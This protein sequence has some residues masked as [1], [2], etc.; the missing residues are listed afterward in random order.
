MSFGGGFFG[1]GTSSKKTYTTQQ[2]VNEAREQNLQIGGSAG[3]VVAP[4]AQVTEAG[5]GAV[6]ASNWSNVYQT[7][8]SSGAKPAEVQKMLDSVFADA[9]AN[10]ESLS[11][12]AESL[13]VGLSDQGKALTDALAATRAPEQSALASLVPV[14]IVGLIVFMVWGH[15]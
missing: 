10:R 4:S 15:A 14:L 2:T 13:S 11:G 5:G 3:T 9:T 8:T 12:L 6:Q 7:I 1:G